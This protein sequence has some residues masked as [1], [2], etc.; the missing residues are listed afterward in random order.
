MWVN[1]GAEKLSNLSKSAQLGRGRTGFPQASVL[2]PTVLASEMGTIL[3]LHRPSAKL[4]IYSVDIYY[5]PVVC[6]QCAGLWR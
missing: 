6:L 1:G 3:T 4:F 2:A 5:A